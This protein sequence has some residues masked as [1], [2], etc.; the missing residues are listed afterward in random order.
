MPAGVDVARTTRSR[1][2]RSVAVSASSIGDV[3]MPPPTARR[4]LSTSLYQSTSS[5]RTSM[6]DCPTVLVLG[7]YRRSLPTNRLQIEQGYASLSFRWMTVHTAKG[8]EAD[9]V[10][11]LGAIAGEYGFPCEIADDPLLGLVFA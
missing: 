9:Y 3:N 4:M 7:R 8:A 11:V 6:S 2:A 10:V 1:S 5:K